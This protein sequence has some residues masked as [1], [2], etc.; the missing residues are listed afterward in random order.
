MVKPSCCRSFLAV[1]IFLKNLPSTL[2]AIILLARLY[3]VESIVGSYLTPV[4]IIVGLIALFFCIESWS[5]FA[6]V[7]HECNHV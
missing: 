5:C 3:Q 7:Y 4:T 1:I 6:A 2:V